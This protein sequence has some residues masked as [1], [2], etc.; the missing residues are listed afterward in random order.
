VQDLVDILGVDETKAREVHDAVQ[1]QGAE[2]KVGSAQS[3]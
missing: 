1:K 2:E 3:A